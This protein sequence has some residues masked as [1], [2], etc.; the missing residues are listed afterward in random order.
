MTTESGKQERG[1]NSWAGL[2]AKGATSKPKPWATPQE[3][4]NVPAPALKARLN[5]CWVHSDLW[6]LHR[7]NRAF[8]ACPWPH[9]MP[10]ALPQAKADLA[11]L[12]LAS[13]TSYS[14]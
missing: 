9:R 1:N 8:S 14:R 6:M 3:P 2:S 10:G 7:L 5:F 11:P 4:G 12:A 13:S